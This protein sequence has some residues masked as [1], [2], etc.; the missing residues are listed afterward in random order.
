MSLYLKS[1]NLVR[2]HYHKQ[3]TFSKYTVVFFGIFTKILL[4]F[5]CITKQPIYGRQPN[6]ALLFNICKSMCH[7]LGLYDSM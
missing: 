6:C 5:D 3:F 7:S 2:K 4:F 1:I